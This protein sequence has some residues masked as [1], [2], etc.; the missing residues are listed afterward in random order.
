MLKSFFGGKLENTDFP[1][2]G[3]QLEKDHFNYIN[4]FYA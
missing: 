4:S 2:N 1:E 3:F